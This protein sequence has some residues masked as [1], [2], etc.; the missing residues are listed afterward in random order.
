MRNSRI[1]A[2]VEVVANHT[3]YTPKQIRGPGR[4]R[5]LVDARHAVMRLAR[6]EGF[7]L[8]EIGGA[9]GRDHTSVHHGCRRAAREIVR[10]AGE[11]MAFVQ[12]AE[13]WWRGSAPVRRY[14]VEVGS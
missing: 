13:R 12:L 9:L 7:S 11:W 14:R 3:G 1:E 4:T 8:S 5:S 2:L 10:S 6:D